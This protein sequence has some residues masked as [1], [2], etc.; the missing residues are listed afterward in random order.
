MGGKLSVRHKQ[1]N[2][3][4]RSLLKSLCHDSL[5]PCC[6]PNRCMYQGPIVYFTGL[7]LELIF[8]FFF[9][10]CWRNIGCLLPRLGR[11]GQTDEGIPGYRP[12]LSSSSRRGTSQRRRPR[13]L[14]KKTI[15]HHELG[16]RPEPF[17][18]LWSSAFIWE[19]AYMTSRSC[20]DSSWAVCITA[21][22][23]SDSDWTACM[24]SRSTPSVG[25]H[26]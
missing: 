19:T 18:V 20:S 4:A 12:S 2:R 10:H 13:P 5:T 15:A 24:T 26:V 25:P 1:K 21:R 6:S 7:D 23:N 17:F 22:P 3:K 16:C 14:S 11:R 8:V 9:V